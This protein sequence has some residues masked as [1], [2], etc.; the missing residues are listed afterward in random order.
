MPFSPRSPL[1]IRFGNVSD[2]NGRA[3][4][5]QKQ[6]AHAFVLFFKMADY[7]GLYKMLQTAANYG[8]KTLVDACLIVDRLLPSLQTPPYSDGALT[9]KQLRLIY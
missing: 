5:R 1:S 6:T 4:L 2:A 3:N 9:Y 8:F 7:T